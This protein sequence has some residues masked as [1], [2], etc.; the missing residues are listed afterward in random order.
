MKSKK[1]G[2][3]DP[4]PCGSGKK[5]K[6]CCQDVETAVRKNK[7]ESERADDLEF[8]L[9]KYRTGLSDDSVH[10]LVEMG[11]PAANV[12]ATVGSMAGGSATIGIAMLSSVGGLAAAWFKRSFKRPT[13]KALEDILLESAQLTVDHIK[14]EAMRDLTLIARD[15]GESLVQLPP[16]LPA[17]CCQRTDTVSDISSTLN[18]SSCLFLHG[19]ADVGKT[20]L[21]LLTARNMN[22]KEIFVDFEYLGN[23]PEFNKF[24]LSAS[25]A[26]L[27]ER[28]ETTGE[29]VHA[30][31][32]VVIL[33]GLPRISEDNL[34]FKQVRQFISHCTYLGLKVIIT[35]VFQ[36]DDE[37]IRTFAENNITIVET[38]KFTDDDI[39]EL[40]TINKAPEKFQKDPWV[41]VFRKC[42]DGHPVFLISMF[43]YL[44]SID[45][46][47]THESFV[48]MLQRR[49]AG[50]LY[51][52]TQRTLS[53]DLNNDERELIYRLGEV[54]YQFSSKE[55]TILSGI[56]PAIKN[57]GE[58]VSKLKDLWIKQIGDDMF[59]L[60]PLVKELGSRNLP[61]ELKKELN[62]KL[63]LNV[64][65]KGEID[66]LDAQAAFMYFTKADDYDLLAHVIG[67]SL[68]AINSYGLDND[69][70]GFGELLLS[71]W[72][73]STL[74]DAM[75]IGHKIMIRSMQIKIL[76]AHKRNIQ[77]QAKDLFDLMQNAGEDFAY[78][79]WGSALVLF[80]ADIT[81]AE[82]CTAINLAY[83][84]YGNAKKQYGRIDIPHRDDSSFE[85][86]ASLL[87][88]SGGYIKNQN[89]AENWVNLLENIDPMYLIDSFKDE[90]FAYEGLRTA[91]TLIAVHE[92]RKSVETRNWEKT[93]ALLDRL[94]RLGM[95][96]GIEI[97][98]ACV[99]RAKIL[100]H[101]EYL[102]DL[103]SAIAVANH[104]NQF[105]KESPSAK[106]LLCEGIGQQFVLANR[107]T[108]GREW[109]EVAVQQPIPFYSEELANSMLY[110]SST[111]ES[112][113]TEKIYDNLEKALNISLSYEIRN[114][115]LSAK[116]YG[117]RAIFFLLNDRNQEAFM[118]LQKAVFTMLESE[119]LDDLQK[120]QWIRL[121]YVCSYFDWKIGKGDFGQYILLDGEP[122][123]K[124]EQGFLL[125][126]KNME[127]KFVLSMCYSSMLALRSLARILGL[128][129][130]VC[131][132][133]KKI[134]EFESVLPIDERDVPYYKV[135]TI[136][137]YL[138]DD[139]YREAIQEGLLLTQSLENKNADIASAALTFGLMYS[140]LLPV[141]FRMIE[142]Y[143]M[144]DRDFDF[145]DIIKL[146]RESLGDH[147]KD[148]QIQ[149]ALSVI[150]KTFILHET[151]NQLISFGN[152][153]KRVSF[154]GTMMSYL[155][156][157]LRYESAPRVAVK[158]QILTVRLTS[159]LL[160][161]EKWVLREFSRLIR[162]YWTNSFP[163]KRLLFDTPRLIQE[164]INEA[165]KAKGDIL[166]LLAILAGGL[167]FD[168]DR[169][170]FPPEDEVK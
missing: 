77:Y 116:A 95:S 70:T 154:I 87:P 163:E 23:F 3:N 145:R 66:L 114:N 102:N 115:W 55:V 119:G 96:T 93:I 135:H 125:P 75:H 166:G 82:K 156:A 91:L 117:E 107:K 78:A 29:L 65:S 149:M 165:V 159:R 35:S 134:K 22:L 142:K 24:D 133:I 2:R 27:I 152:E 36:P 94:E 160:S 71:I 17:D 137:A 140:T 12:L 143:L 50:E 45:W 88:I 162:V 26:F 123:T 90:D 132:I 136:R 97:L 62:H 130:E 47:I 18:N 170:D 146:V 98:L 127:E 11:I 169:I 42:T 168:L 109:L 101:A 147:C 120:D 39:T 68:H 53:N 138:D 19:E 157:C 89:D 13:Q 111:L 5:L 108:E 131:V 51:D 153:N 72:S 105:L 61:E 167:G 83:R 129:N 60:S 124:I 15:T 81:F 113:E 10:D 118:S 85:L 158:H 6:Y 28:W 46:K 30:N 74:P 126:Y 25:L 48:A 161:A 41:K 57:P 40:L 104:I 58:I 34:L 164:E 79:V 20:I 21:A 49:Y 31:K 56:N 69:N 59:S 86:T 9:I 33:D 141:Y 38:P 44:A 128:N 144:K 100:M 67:K 84:H 73:N 150:D 110:Y 43:K 14:N 64:L 7:S 121:T 16:P 139:N 8:Q 99:A 1:I 32:E 54:I 52:R 92:G 80:F 4:C 76:S 151:G 106:L 112:S 37:F 155:G 63:G 103:D 122:H 148:A